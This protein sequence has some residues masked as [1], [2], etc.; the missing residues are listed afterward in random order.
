VRINFAATRF[1]S[2]P[3]IAVASFVVDR[4]S[5]HLAISPRLTPGLLLL[6]LLLLP[7]PLSIH[8][9]VKLFF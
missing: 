8:D 5:A 4:T 9:V 7:P 3:G 2:P 1:L 6:L